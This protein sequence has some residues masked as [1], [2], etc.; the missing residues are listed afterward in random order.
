MAKTSIPKLEIIHLDGAPETPKFPERIG[1]Y[2]IKGIHD[3]YHHVMYG[4]HESGLEV[5]LKTSK[6]YS[7][8]GMD[9]VLVGDMCL[10]YEYGVHSELDHPNI[11]PPVELLEQEG[12]YY[13]VVPAVGISDFN[14]ELAF[15]RNFSEQKKLSLLRQVAGALN[16]CHKNGVVHC[17]VKGSNIRVDKNTAVLIDFGAARKPGD[18]HF[19]IDRVHMSTPSIVAPEHLNDNIITPGVDVFSFACTAYEILTGQV[20][21]YY[22]GFG[23][24]S[25]KKPMHAL[26][27][28]EKFGKAALLLIDGMSIDHK[29]R[30]GMDE[31][32]DALR[33]ET[34][35]FG[36]PPSEDSLEPS[37]VRV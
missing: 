6:P 20:P 9:P 16:Y 18:Y 24:I 14:P 11:V 12:K 34:V 31:I 36:L 29:L 22:N 33:E 2:A 30:P 28:I 23:Y 8:E 13:L 32:E 5:V 15:V 26:N 27:K 17:D 25:Y 7:L 37:P 10:W 4:K 1:P 19:V 3:N 35:R 21:F